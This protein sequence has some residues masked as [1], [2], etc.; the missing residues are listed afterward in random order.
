VKP[1]TRCQ[2]TTTDQSTARVGEE[3][4]ATLAVYRTDT[5]LDGIAFGM[6]AI[7]AAGAGSAL[8][9]GGAVAAGWNFWRAPL[10]HLSDRRGSGVVSGRRS[11]S[12]G[13]IR[14]GSVSTRPSGVWA[15]PT[16]AAN[17]SPARAG[18]PSTRPASDVSVSP[19]WTVTQETGVGSSELVGAT[20]TTWFAPGTRRRTT[21]GRTPGGSGVGLPGGTR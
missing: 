10:R 2:I 8:S 5:R 15:W 9:R 6:N 19:G 16:L 20:S 12:P 1:C 18:S 3:P 17:S 21:S 7:V 14:S 11:R 4:L 13:Q